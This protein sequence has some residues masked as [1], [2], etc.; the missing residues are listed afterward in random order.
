[1]SWEIKIPFQSRDQTISEALAAGVDQAIERGEDR[2]VTTQ[3]LLNSSGTMGELIDH[4]GSLDAEGQ[5]RVLDGARKAAGLEASEDIDSRERFQRHNRALPPGRD[6]DGRQFVG[7]AEPNCMARPL[8]EMGAPVPVTDRVWW[9]DRH[10]DQAGPDD[11]LP[12]DDLRPRF[13][14]MTMQL[15]PSMAEEKR[16]KEEDRKREEAARERRERRERRRQE[17]EALDAVKR[18]YV[19]QAAPINVAGFWVRPDGRIVE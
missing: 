17:S 11:H 4:L 19:E 18:R 3:I 7:C 2:D 10:K 15:L 5:R 14:P 16:L 1:M 12:P 13:D 6:A 8:D 9:C